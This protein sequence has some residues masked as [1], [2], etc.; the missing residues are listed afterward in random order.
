MGAEKA[1]AFSP[2]EGLD[3]RAAQSRTPNSPSGASDVLNAAMQLG[4][5]SAMQL[6]QAIRAA[7]HSYTADATE[8]DSGV[9]SN[10]SSDGT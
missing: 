6:K 1:P 10:A 2:S 4:D 9:D 8:Q 3:L 5:Q 7:A